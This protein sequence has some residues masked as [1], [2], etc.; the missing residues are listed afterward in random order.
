[1]FSD[2]NIYLVIAIIGASLF[3]C[4]TLML[5]FGGDLQVHGVGAHAD[6]AD[7]STHESNEYFSILTV[8]SF[9]AFLMGLGCM[10]LVASSTWEL[11]PIVSLIMAVVFGGF[12]MWLNSWM[13]LKIKL[14][15]SS[16]VMDPASAIGTRGQVYLAIPENGV[17]QIEVCIS[18]KRVVVQART[19]SGES[20]ASFKAIEVVSA[21]SAGT[22]TVKAVE[23]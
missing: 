11:S 2:D 17:G 21:D 16:S 1:M 5:L 20:L 10:G 13:L 4:K 23:K 3:A 8:Q 15:N 18:G 19:E 6:M 22:M 12:L 9:L 14:L 7:H